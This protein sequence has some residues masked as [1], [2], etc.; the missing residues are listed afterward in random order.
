MKNFLRG[1]FWL[2]VS[3]ALLFFVVSV[4]ASHAGAKID[5]EL[6]SLMDSL[7][8]DTELSV[9]VGLAGEADLASFKDEK[10][11]SKRRKGIVRELKKYG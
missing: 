10:D 8:P 11:K 3:L 2:S 1:R 6:A 7:D 9:I 4:S 5:S